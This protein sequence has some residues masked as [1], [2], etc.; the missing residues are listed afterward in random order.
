[1][2]TRVVN[3]RLE[4]YD[5]YIGRA[6]RGEK[7]THG[8]PYIVSPQQPLGTTVNKLY[9]EH[10]HFKLKN[11]PKYFDEVVKLVERKKRQGGKLTLGCFCADSGGLTAGTPPYICHGQVIAEFI[12]ERCP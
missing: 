10:F 6:G 4:P 9:R 5:V 1:M 2:K 7:G 12:D 3:I 11:D 8:N